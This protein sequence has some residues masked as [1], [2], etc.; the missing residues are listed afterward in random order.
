MTAKAPSLRTKLL[1]GASIGSLLLSGVAAAQ[2]RSG[3]RIA[4]GRGG[5]DPAAAAARAAQQQAA[6][7]AE[8]NSASRR[9]IE[10]FRRA[11]ETRQQMFDAQAAA[12]AAAQAAQSNVPNGLGEGGLQVAN[13]VELDPS[14][15]IG[16]EGPVQSQGE[17]GR[18]N[19]SIDQTE[20]KAILTWDSFNVGR[21][22]DLA[23][24]QGGADWV[25]LNRVTGANADPSQILG[26]I[27]A[28][29]TVLILNQN[30]VI[31][32]GASQVNVRNLVASTAEIDNDAF[33][34]RGIYSNLAGQDYAH[35][36]TDAG[37]AVTVEAGAQIN[38]N[39]PESVTA[40]GGYVLLMGTEVTNEGTITTPMGQALLAAGDDFIVRQG[41][42]T[43]SNSSSTTRG[44]EVRGFIDE[45]STSGTVVNAGL[46]EA[47]QG[48]ITL[49]GRTI[50]Q[51]GVAIATTS[52]NQRGTIHLL[53]SASDEQGSVTLGEDSLTTVMPELE[54]E[55]TAL[56]S[57]RDALIEQS[58]D[59]N[60][61]R[62]LDSVT[63]GFDNLSLLDDRL[64]LSRI[65]IV[66]GGNVLFEGGSQTR[67]QGGQIAVQAVGVD[68]PA[69]GAINGRITVEDG[70]LVD[71]SGVQGVALD[72]ESN[73]IVVN[74]QGNEMRDSPVN[75]END[76]LRSQDVWIDVRDLVLLPDGTGG[77]E[78]DR[79][80]TG[81]GFLE[82]GG[83]VG[84]ME[85]DIGEWTAV[86]GTIAF[87][88]R[89]VVAQEGA[90]FDVSGGSLDYQAGWV[91]SSRVLGSDGK[92]YDI[93]RLP[94]G[95][96]VVGYG[97][98]FTREH[99]RWGAAYTEV[100]SHPLFSSRS[101][102]RWEDGYS[103]GRD[104]GRL[105]LSAP[106][107][108]M[109]GEVVAEVIDGEWQTKA[110]ADGITDGYD[111]GA[112]TVAKAGSL[113][114]GGNAALGSLGYTYDSDIQVGDFAD[115]GG[116]LGEGALVSEDRTGT[117]WLDAGYLNDL[118]L[119]GLEL[120]T[121]TTIGIDSAL[122]LADGGELVLRG[123]DIGINAD[124]TARSGSVLATNA[125]KLARYVETTPRAALIDGNSHIA[126]GEGVTLDMR[127]LWV[128]APGDG[129]DAGLLAHID[130]GSVTLESTHLVSVGEDALI[131][132]SSGAALLADRS[133]VGGTG[134]DVTLRTNMRVGAT[135]EHGD[136]NITLDGDI[137]GY[138][139]A[140]AGTLTIDSG[141][142]VSIG[143]EVLEENGTLGAGEI[144]KVYLTLGEDVDLAAGD[145]L[146]FDYSFTRTHVQPGEKFGDA[147]V[148]FRPT[149][150]DEYLTTA[151]DWT[152]PSPAANYIRIVYFDPSG[153]Q[154]VQQVTAGETNPPTIPAGSRIQQM[155]VPINA[156]PE[157]TLPADV[158]TSGLPM[159]NPSRFTYNAGEALTAD[160]TIPAGTF[161]PAGATFGRDV[162]VKETRQISTDLFDNG[163]A[164]YA[165]NGQQGLVVT[166]GAQIEVERPVWR[167]ADGMIDLPTGSD[168]MAALELWAPPLYMAD[169]ETG[170]LTQRG[171]AS[172]SLRALHPDT[173]GFSGPIAIERDAEIRVDPG[174]T[175]D[176]RN[177]LRSMDIDGRLIAPGGTINLVNDASTSVGAS[178]AVMLRVGENA[179]LDV[180]GD[181]FVTTDV[182]GRRF[183]LVR[184]G[185]TINLG[186][187]QRNRHPSTH[188][189]EVSPLAIN[190]EEGAYLDL[191]GGEETLLDIYPGKSGVAVAGDGGTLAISSNN[192]IV[193]DGTVDA[194]AGGQNA[195]GGTLDIMLEGTFASGETDAH[196]LRTVTIGA[197]RSTAEDASGHGR[198]VLGVDQIEAGGYDSLSIWSRDEI[199]FEGDVDLAL[200]RSINL[201]H[202]IFSL[203]QDTLDASVNIAAPY[204]R[205]G[206]RGP[207][208]VPPGSESGSNSG[209]FPGLNDTNHVGSALLDP[210]SR[211]VAEADL[212]DIVDGATIFGGKSTRSTGISGST[213]VELPGFA[214]VDLISSGD[215]RFTDGG[216]VAQRELTLT[217][218]RLY[219]TTHAAG[220]I[221]VGVG[222]EGT[223]G[224][225][226]EDAVVRFP[227]YGS[228]ELAT[229]HS[230]FG[231]LF[232]LAPKIEQGGALFAP[233]GQISF[234]VLGNS[235][236]GSNFPSYL[237]RY[238]VSE[239][240]LL[241]GSLTSLSAEGLVLPYGGTADGIQYRYNGDE[242]EFDYIGAQRTEQQDRTDGGVIFGVSDFIAE[243]GAVID[244]TGGG[245]LQGAGFRSGRGGSVDLRYTPLGN[246]NPYYGSA[247]GREVYAILPGYESGY[248]PVDPTFGDVP[249]GRQITIGDDVPGLPAG[250]YTLLPAEYALM[251][252]AFRVELGAEV[253]FD[254]G[255]ASTT[256]GITR[257][258][259][260]MGTA[261]SDVYDALPRDVMVMSGE[262][263][264]E[265][266]DYNMTTM[267]EWAEA[268]MARYGNPRILNAL[269]PAD[270]RPINF[271]FGFSQT[272]VDVE[273]TSFSFDAT[274]LNDA[275]EGGRG[276]MVNFYGAPIEVLGAE[277]E[278]SS[279]YV[280]LR[281]S[282]LNA[283]GADVLGL[284]INGVSD[285]GLGVSGN[286]VLRSGSE[287]KAG[288]VLLGGT[289]GANQV[290][291]EDDA[292]IDTR[293]LGEAGWTL[294]D[295]FQLGFR[296]SGNSLVAVSNDTLSF[297]QA[298]G[299]GSISI[300]DG[301]SLQ[302]DGSVVLVGPGG[303]ELGDIR[304]TAGDLLL[305]V[306]DINIGEE[307]ALAA[308]DEAGVLSPGWQLSQ[309]I[310][311][312]L[313]RPS[314]G[315]G[316]GNLR[317]QAS[318][319][320]NFIGDVT[321]DTFDPAT[322]ESSASISLISPAIYGL[323]DEGD[324]ATIRT[325]RL[326]L[327]GLIYGEYVN[328][329]VTNWFVAEPGPVIPEGA[330]TGGGAFRVDAREVLFGDGEGA[331][332]NPATNLERPQLMLGFED[333][334]FAASERI[335]SNYIGSLSVYREQTG[336]DAFAGGNLTLTTALLTGEAG[337][338]MAYNAGGDLLVRRP[339]DAGDV[340]MAAQ[341]FGA[342]IRL[343]GETVDIA[344]TIAAPS[345]LLE[346]R[347]EGDLTLAGGAV[348]DLSGRPVE[349][350]EEVRHGFG[351]DLVLTSLGGSI[352]QSADSTID[353]SADYSDSGSITAIANEGRVDLAGTLIAGH[354]PAEGDED[355]ADY[356][357]G[358]VDVRAG[359][360]VDFVGLNQRLNARAFD[361]L[362]RFETG[363]GDLTIGSEVQA[364]H[365]SVTA[366]GG[367]LTV[368]GTLR[369]GGQYAGSI[370][371]AARDNL[372]VSDGAVL[373]ASGE[374][375]RL[376]S[377]GGAIEGANRALIDL[378][379]TEGRLVLGDGVAMDVGAGGEA[380]GTIDLNARRLGGVRGNDVAVDTGSGLSVDGAKRVAVNGF[381]RYDDAPVDPED[382]GG[383]IVDQAYLDRLHEDSTIFVDGALANGALQ[384]RLAGLRQATGGALQ[385]RPG[386][387]IVSASED[388]NLRV[389][390]DLDFSGYRY[391]PDVDPAVRGSGFAGVVSLRAGGDLIVNGNINDG[392]GLPLVT[393][394]D[395]I[396]V[397]Y[398]PGSGIVDSRGQLLQDFVLPEEL[399]LRPGWSLGNIYRYGGELPFD[400]TTTGN[401]RVN[402][403][404]TVVLDVTITLR[405]PIFRNVELTADMILP[406]PV[407]DTA[408]G[409]MYS[410]TVPAGT[411]IGQM[412]VPVGTVMK[413]GSYVP[414]TI[415]IENLTIPAGTDLTGIFAGGVA[416]ADTAITLPAGTIL[417]Q[418]LQTAGFG[419]ETLQQTIWTTAPML[420][421]GSESW[422]MR[423][424]AGANLTSADYRAVR[425][426]GVGD[427]ILDNPVSVVTAYGSDHL[428]E[429]VSVIRTG[430]G[431]LDLIAA[432]DYRQ[433]SRFGIY[434]AG[435]W[436]DTEATRPG[437]ALNQ[438]RATFADGSVL[439]SDF[440]EYEDAVAGYQPWFTT[441][442]GYVTVDVGRDM[443]GHMS[444]QQVGTQTR[445]NHA[446]GDW[447]WHQGAP[448]IG[449]Q[450]AWWINFGT[451]ARQMDDRAG[452]PGA[453]Y[454]P[455]FDGIGTLGGGN[456]TV[457]A[458]RDFGAY[459]YVTNTAY[460]GALALAVGSS[461]WVDADGTIHRT[462][463]GDLSLNVGRQINPVQ[464]SN[465]AIDSYLPGTLTNLR[466]DID[467]TAGSIGQ[468]WKT[469]EVNNME[470]DRDPRPDSY[471]QFNDTDGYGALTI[472]PGDGVATLNSR[473]DMVATVF[474]P[475]LQNTP[476]LV[477]VE[478]DGQIGA[479]Q[480]WFTQFTDAT[481]VN[482]F[483]AGGDL[484]IGS[485]NFG[486]YQGPA[487]VSAIAA[488]GSL[489]GIGRVAG[490]ESIDLMP[491]DDGTAEFL[492]SDTI[493]YL[494][495]R[496]SG[497]PES[498]LATPR[499][500]AWGVL[501]ESQMGDPI[502][503]NV[504]GN[505]TYGDL[506]AHGA[507][508]A[509]ART[510]KV[511]PVL[512]YARDGD[513]INANFGTLLTDR[514]TQELS[515][516]SGYPAYIRA[517]RDI[518][519][520]GSGAPSFS[521]SGS[522]FL[523]SFA[524]DISIIDAGRDL[525][526]IEAMVAGPGTLELNA[527]RSFYQDDKGVLR[528][529]GRI[530]S[531]AS[532]APTGGADIAVTVGAG[533]G[534]PN[535]AA[536]RDAY[537]DPANLAD[538]E[539]PLADQHGMVAKIY[540]EELVEWLEG[541]WPE[542]AEQFGSDEEA[543][544]YFDALA[545]E[546]QRIFLRDIYYEELRI[547]GREYSGK[548]ESGRR[549]SYLRGRQMVETLFPGIDSEE[550]TSP[551][552]GEFVQF[553][554][555]SVA[556]MIRTEFGGDIQMLA[557]GGGVTLGLNAI[558]PENGDNGLLTQGT[559]N[560]Q[561]Y[562]QGDIA[563]GL[564]R[565]FTTFGGDIFGWSAAG[566]INAG[567]G[568]NTTVLYTPPRRVYDDIGN[569]A[570]SPQVPSTGAGIA[571]LAPLPEIPS[572]DV[573]LIAPLGVIDAGEAG[574]RVSGD[575][576]LAALQV[577]NAANIQVEGEAT[578]I[579]V[580]AAVNTG[581]LTAASSASSAVAAQAADLAERSRPQTRTEIP[582]ILNV[583]FLGFGE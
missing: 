458:G 536:V 289:S 569:V 535:F 579:P 41:Y 92:L 222:P 390:D 479:T 199:R 188:L 503:T 149:S 426:D 521:G 241:S 582:T 258:T 77:Y 46:I 406:Y 509:V 48:D 251:P 29:G 483:S 104:A 466:G 2:D 186:S 447:L 180:S 449:Q 474:D 407:E 130:G 277:G 203:S 293:G 505:Y 67:A 246:S 217:A 291:I 552:E 578:G 404:S 140:G 102:A 202:G 326:T 275:G 290:V 270:V 83:H 125:V 453:R 565:I 325:D 21:E 352:L 126:V 517:G 75:R 42:G 209:Y 127:G 38:T 132:V 392:F 216:L 480:T 25:A 377:D 211:F 189:Y 116:G 413:A 400:I 554:T 151:A 405:D 492:A 349:F 437:G 60:A 190:I 470:S 8:T 15:W 414:A 305:V 523:H 214:S 95:V 338:N 40:G 549:G 395:E 247:E 185:G 500:P 113:I 171:G 489:Y 567:R 23:F 150:E 210:N 558:R 555:G 317:L 443:F 465:G 158:F 240:T 57:R 101:Y 184:D 314:E 419:G 576:N 244:V 452:R 379:S 398:D 533:V 229:P 428:Y 570:L 139:A 401:T 416:E 253:G 271:N 179:V 332:L 281:D 537:L 574:I 70:A 133:F 49:T 336:E 264:R 13:G 63:G 47:Q 435:T 408:T 366:N 283:L 524:D 367:D 530:G 322:G 318:N 534:G 14:L 351:G 312:G 198:M 34:E 580:V 396:Q 560:V 471:S 105:I 193:L 249:L 520:L 478:V 526:W 353:V 88:A 172:L 248:A 487:R 85:H 361:Y 384:S 259:A 499:N 545:P 375:L 371:L 488:G 315:E 164:Q 516:F 155:L 461:G 64:D 402:S 451:Y 122:T 91:R 245:T 469:F 334:E 141:G 577:L 548:I 169:V 370:R 98:A 152:L 432:R 409:I 276:G 107:V 546:H 11:A 173:D 512:I 306:E 260:R 194:R 337:S 491:S 121:N 308:A 481:R 430:T 157:Y 342:Q 36:F 96:E 118:A 510:Q 111:V 498:V 411:T 448:E 381:W 208:P 176:V 568:A 3:G 439:G 51:D 196:P 279:E 330:G 112:H 563:L 463:G 467:V 514:T 459:E 506:F 273:N 423:M 201:S 378:S 144:A 495:V 310:L 223:R 363:A 572:G 233:L 128:N 31:F 365:I 207:L 136:A 307:A 355:S 110:R 518:V 228:G 525:I 403:G 131:D 399:Q 357:G 462:G 484:T 148:N 53:N 32:G 106:T 532:S 559:G 444:G 69:E 45:E 154:Q 531:D 204:I 490:G 450:A 17:D 333:V 302:S 420:A 473:G 146:A 117:I 321:L 331:F 335:T 311:D 165:I 129:G 529:L 55:D 257:T 542:D 215:M 374:E 340:D 218:E 397:D 285:L 72:M 299:D 177:G 239:V 156:L 87:A 566:D 61:R 52:V 206:G 486:G 178:N 100:Y 147:L 356:R 213:D 301:A 153:A 22:T 35:A 220:R 93:G 261:N 167:A 269:L 527:G 494:W 278:A 76:E 415:Y 56:N 50:R 134:G 284:A 287:L 393:P 135:N 485:E 553:S 123:A 345:G 191:S 175:I 205:F 90:V 99:E 424:V 108:L 187:D 550:G 369:G 522:L 475:G 168:P 235:R 242:V 120:N 427:M 364:Q 286:I 362:R 221:Q 493:Y 418:Y 181:S 497:A 78:G 496:T 464:A 456:L 7:A 82:V 238:P 368:N 387:E 507:D 477:G 386:I 74:I 124:V 183:G 343:S 33:L 237:F 137:L 346:V 80:Y 323:G 476:A 300:A 296:G 320:I 225:A 583:R 174:Q 19:V 429:G 27:K 508:T 94:A 10:A 192:Q 571:T 162:A 557:P 438:P 551:Y 544:A 295:G 564:S 394:D 341:D 145:I 385:L 89:E 347:S 380:L 143:G 329:Q 292:S 316:F 109:E 581:A 65:E 446:V 436:I 54:S 236:M 421:S 30:G 182:Q 114:V 410:G 391:G 354:T 501:P 383:Q 263:L 422:N 256:A 119:G 254:A 43:E 252:G 84:N 195:F 298:L 282:D 62:H 339:D 28:E 504:S 16:A 81:G 319:S 66:T 433:D 328:T 412:S 272:A 274:L 200:G 20:Q 324:T 528:S 313:L 441:G 58:D 575:I 37:G 297:G 454:L 280:T 358:S 417:P 39:A 360:I 457:S 373:D 163:F 511:D 266:S 515:Y 472:F 440:A 142:A 227:R 24:N 562:S 382:A 103:V 161:L 159:F 460:R 160:L 231:K 540:T 243:E 250:T 115:L 561:I 262:T 425:Q 482:L 97:N 304:L 294:E 268:E 541:R 344:G 166:E 224:E 372:I 226:E 73:S 212:I 389:A 18:T 68:S 9:A 445:S 197:V 44:N 303:V 59:A 431:D 519:G 219:P 234:G 4:N 6:R 556:G 502:L 265:H 376:D 468:V 547:G 255:R 513:I 538:P 543:L 79:W 434:T 267:T 442:G 232:I 327:A 350:F 388:G 309:T 455:A 1:I 26:S 539:R 12:R 573:D 359:E 71:V 170:T 138:G 86:G 288:T 348:I 5:V 230:A